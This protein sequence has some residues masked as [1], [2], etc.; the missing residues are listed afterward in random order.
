MKK[1]DEN[2]IILKQWVRVFLIIVVI[3]IMV[4]SAFSVLK[5]LNP[6]KGSKKKEY[7]YSYTT[8]LDYRVY[9]KNNNFFNTPYMGMNK[10]YITSLIDHIEVDAK[11]SFKS[12]E[13]LDYTY[14][15]EII[16][17]AR[18]M[19]EDSDGKKVD[20]WSKI[21]PIS[22]LET[23]SGSGK[24]FNISKTVNVD[25]NAYNQVLTDF[26]NQF[27]LSV[28][29]RVDLTLNVNINAGLK[30]SKNKTLQNSEK[31]NLQMPLL[32]QTLRIKPDYINNGG[33]T[34]YNNT[35]TQ[36]TRNMPLLILGS[37]I[38]IVSLVLFIKLVKSLLVITRKSEY[39]LAV[40]KIMKEYGDIIAETHN[41]PDLSNY[42]IVDIKNFND[43]V[44]IEEELHAPIMYYE[45]KENSKCV[46]LILSQKIAYR[47]E[48]KEMDF[49]HFNSGSDEDDT[50][51]HFDDNDISKIKNI[52]DIEEK[53]E[54]IDRILSENEEYLHKDK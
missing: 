5:A 3:A 53:K 17:T 10:Q 38:F 50:D 13:D 34:I 9:L 20:V 46:F 27:G 33:D 41:M 1:K 29:A 43:M 12:D 26:R 51:Y 21:Y 15:Y 52:D 54:E 48:L 4:I 25:Y 28:D 6:Q 30:G 47:L 31:M 35:Q 8:N 18:G 42:D 37:V 2:K 14:S 7:S 40:N 44:D 49:D 16:A 22:N 23:N 11:Y 36:S 19:A 32:V 39:I 24:E 45:I